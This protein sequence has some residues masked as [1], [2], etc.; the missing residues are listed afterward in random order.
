MGLQVVGEPCLLECPSFVDLVL[1][2]HLGNQAVLQTTPVLTQLGKE[3]AINGNAVELDVSNGLRIPTTQQ[4]LAQAG[5]FEEELLH[6]AEQ[7]AGGH[8]PPCRPASARLF[9]ADTG[10]DRRSRRSQSPEYARNRAC[11]VI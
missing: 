2:I 1:V 8:S 7:L 5:V 4:R 9:N 10:V 11:A 3:F 6:R